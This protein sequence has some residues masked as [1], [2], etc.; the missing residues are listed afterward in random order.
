MLNTRRRWLIVC[1]TAMSLAA[2]TGFAAL[3]A[4]ADEPA[5]PADPQ[6]QPLSSAPD[7]L[8]ARNGMRRADA[9]ASVVTK[10]GTQL[11][12]NRAN[13]VT[14]LTTKDGSGHC[15]PD[16]EIPAGLGLGVAMCLP[17]LP[18]DQ[19]RVTAIVPAW[20]KSATLDAGSL[21][22]VASAVDGGVAFEISRA[23]L[24][25]GTPLRVGW[26]AG[27]DGG[28]GSASVPVDDMLVDAVCEPG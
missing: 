8:L 12:T 15:V 10:A 7:P 25:V 26:T 2:A 21:R 19:L 18:S 23:N 27:A 3:A 24:A 20:V 5:P 4:G 28:A 11:Y 13:S 17:D 6:S 9:R 16:A 22:T 14:C 1:T